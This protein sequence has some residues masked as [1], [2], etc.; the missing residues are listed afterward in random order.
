[1]TQG[2]ISCFVKCNRKRKRRRNWVRRMSFKWIWHFPKLAGAQ[3]LA[4]NH[5]GKPQS[6]FQLLT[7]PIRFQDYFNN[8]QEITFY[9]LHS[10]FFCPIAFESNG[11]SDEW[12][13]S[14][15]LADMRSKS[16]SC[17]L[18]WHQEKKELDWWLQ[19]W[20]LIF[21]AQI[22]SLWENREEA[23]NWTRRDLSYVKI[24]IFGKTEGRQNNIHYLAVRKCEAWCR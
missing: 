18:L 23:K 4:R 10:C 11:E 19:T 14:P 1:M 22:R 7:W 2:T 3:Q 21:A 15:F 5:K 17:P 8:L 6:G 13:T 24:Y 12:K 16:S 9:A 20:V